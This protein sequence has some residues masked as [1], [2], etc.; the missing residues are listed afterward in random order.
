[1][2]KNILGNVKLEDIDYI[3]PTMHKHL[4]WV[5]DLETLDTAETAVVPEISATA[6]EIDTGE[7]ITERTLHLPIQDQI[8]AGRTISESTLGFWFSQS[9][10]AQSKLLNS[11]SEIREEKSLPELESLERQLATLHHSVREVSANWAERKNCSPEP[12][13]WGNGIRFDLIKTSNLFSSVGMD[14]PWQYWAERDA[15]TFMN[16]LP[17][18]KSAV[19]SDFKGVPHYGKHDCFNELRYLVL[20]YNI[21]QK[22]NC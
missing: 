6:F 12:L 13:V 15:R 3:K 7:I 8:D 19:M 21:I 16:L 11:F 22:L 17:H 10:Q 18:V 20:G 4:N 2:N 9:K 5:F 14:D 1:M